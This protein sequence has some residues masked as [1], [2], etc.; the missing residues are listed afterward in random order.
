MFKKKKCQRCG[1]KI[2]EDYDF[3]PHCG[4]ANREFNEEDWGMLGKNDLEGMDDMKLPMGFNMLFRSLV[5]NLNKEM[6]RLDKEMK[7]QGPKKGI[8][9]KGVSIS[10]STAGDQP[11]KIKV[12]SFGDK[13]PVKTQ[14]VKKIKQPVKRVLK[15]FSK[16]K[17]DKIKKMKKEEPST[18][19]RRFSDKVVY[20]IDIP[21]VKSMDDVSIVKLENSIEIK[22]L[23]KDKVYDKIIPISLPIIDYILEKERLVL[24]F[25]DKS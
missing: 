3:C 17:L 21:G 7:K 4:R 2:N 14:R 8:D 15:N 1:K 13:P 9:K 24:E 11:P 10:I 25:G 20:E 19:I 12:R 18:N 6:T 16:E 5:K 22:A 23:T